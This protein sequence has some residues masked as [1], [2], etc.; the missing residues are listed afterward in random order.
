MRDETR[1]DWKNHVISIK[2][3]A[4]SLLATP[5]T[6]KEMARLVAW[7]TRYDEARVS[8]FKEG[9]VLKELDPAQG[10]QVVL[11]SDDQWCQ[12]PGSINDPAVL[13]QLCDRILRDNVQISG[14]VDVSQGANNLRLVK[15]L[16]LSMEGDEGQSYRL[17]SVY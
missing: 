3:T 17:D 12:L 5:T 6:K 15:S 2:T 14:I 7:S 1:V 8:H 16:C 4:M 9:L 11:F 10:Q 13:R